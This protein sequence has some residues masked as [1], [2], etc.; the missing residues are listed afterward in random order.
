MSTNEIT[1]Q[2]I[3]ILMKYS[4]SEHKAEEIKPETNLLADLKINSARLVDIIIDFEDKFDIE[5]DDD[6]ADGVATL[7]NAVDLINTLVAA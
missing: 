4:K 2:V 3:E 6:A 5:I 1:N 7:K